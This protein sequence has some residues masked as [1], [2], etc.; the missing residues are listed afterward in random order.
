MDQFLEEYK[1]EVDFAR[2]D[3]PAAPPLWYGQYAIVVAVLGRAQLCVSRD[4][5]IFTWNGLETAT[6]APSVPLKLWS[7][8]ADDLLTRMVAGA[9]DR[10]MTHHYMR[11]LTGALLALRTTELSA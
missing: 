10:R 8:A 4:C 7:G 11:A 9:A 6:I 1:Y 5:R 2:V 3:G